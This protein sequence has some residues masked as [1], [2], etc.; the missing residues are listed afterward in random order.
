VINA[1][2]SGERRLTFDQKENKRPVFI[3]NSEIVFDSRR[4]DGWLE[5]YML[6]LNNPSSVRRLTRNAE[7]RDNYQPTRLGARQIAYAQTSGGMPVICTLN[8]DT[9]SP[10]CLPRVGTI[11][12]NEPAGT[13]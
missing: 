13:W 9:P 4:E 7:G 12:D 10:Q 2:R 5:I 1:D 6:D 8:V 11:G 3:S